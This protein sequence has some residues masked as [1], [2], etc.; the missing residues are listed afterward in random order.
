MR[1]LKSLL[2]TLTVGSIAACGGPAGTPS[3]SA[4][5]EAAISSESA[6]TSSQI[7]HVFV[8]AMENHDANQIIGNATN[9]PYINGTLL[10]QYAQATNFNDELALSIPSEPHYVWLEAGTNAFS[11]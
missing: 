10:P 7:K 11:D 4:T 2:F 8:I 9:A 6:L 3:N 1:A 5:D